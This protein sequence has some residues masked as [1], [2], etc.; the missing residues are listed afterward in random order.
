MTSIYNS[1]EKHEIIKRFRREINFK[2]EI[3]NYFRAL[4]KSYIIFW[5]IYKRK[6]PIF[7]YHIALSLTSIV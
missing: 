6:N 2:F 3:N 4:M 1:D 5:H 7:S